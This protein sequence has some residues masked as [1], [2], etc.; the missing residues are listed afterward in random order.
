MQ[1]KR[2]RKDRVEWLLPSFNGS[3]DCQQPLW[4]I[5]LAAKGVGTGRQRRHPAAQA[6]PGH[7]R[8][9]QEVDVVLENSR[10][11]LV[12]VEIKSAAS[13]GKKDFQGIERFAETVGDRFHRGA[14]LYAGSQA[15]S[16]GKRLHALPI[17]SIWH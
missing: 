9:G 5:H 8:S 12:A 11:Q 14:V 7:G 17:P 4:R 15:V 6:A 16:F 10:G 2:A 13:V 3:Y 1:G